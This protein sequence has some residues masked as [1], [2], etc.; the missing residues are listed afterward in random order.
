VL[1]PEICTYT[2]DANAF[3]VPRLGKRAS[4]RRGL[5]THHAPVWRLPLS[6]GTAVRFRWRRCLVAFSDAHGMPMLQNWDCGPTAIGRLIRTRRS[7]AYINT[8]IAPM[9]RGSVQLP[10]RKKGLVQDLRG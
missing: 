3:R 8:A 2:G 10:G 6:P 7:T 4:R 5:P 1:A 9:V